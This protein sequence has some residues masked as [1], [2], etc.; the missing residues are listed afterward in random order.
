MTWRP[1]PRRRKAGIVSMRSNTAWSACTA[2][3]RRARSRHQRERCPAPHVRSS[4]THS[5]TRSR[6]N[7]QRHLPTHEARRRT[8]ATRRRRSSPR[9]GGGLPRATGS[10]RCAPENESLPQPRRA[11]SHRP[12]AKTSAGKDTTPSPIAP[13][14]RSSSSSF[15]SRQ[16]QVARTSGL[17]LTYRQL[18]ASPSR[19][20]RATPVCLTDRRIGGADV[21]EWGTPDDTSP[22]APT[23]GDVGAVRTE[24][25]PATL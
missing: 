14:M 13:P 17:S 15:S 24:A 25:S 20:P 1:R 10:Q 23:D 3:W 6:E 12:D 18:S 16:G 21:T 22:T 9:Q 4:C 2:T 11:S 19:S 7:S 5:R 8:S